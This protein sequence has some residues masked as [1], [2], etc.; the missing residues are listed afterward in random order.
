MALEGIGMR[1]LLAKM[2]IKINKRIFATTIGIALCVMYL[3]GT[4]SMVSGLHTGT[5][6]TADL[7]EK[8]FLVVY[9]GYTLSKSEIE[10]DVITAIP[11]RFAACIIVVANV[12][13][14]ETRVLT[15]EDPHNILGGG[16]ITLI[17]EVL[18]GTGFEIGNV[19]KLEITTD[20][21]S[22]SMNIT[23]KYERY[24]SA[25]FPDNWIL[26]SETTTRSLNPELGDSYSF[27]VIPEDN[28]QAI[29]YFEKNG[30]NIMQSVS[31][32][33][34]FELGFYQVEGNLWAVVASS[35]VV[36]VILVYNVMRIETQYRVPD[37]KIIKYLGASPKIVMYVFLFQALFISCVGASTFSSFR[38][39]L[40]LVLE[41]Y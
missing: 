9:D 1:N 10:S 23:S 12:S 32:V 20:Y 29:S 18:P 16:N 33:E 25:I 39:S 6:N 27:I 17:D 3:V 15:I 30:F 37:I 5:K 7:F 19:S 38:P 26:A 21:A 34:F 8:G 4:M 35:A 2:I 24:T 31:I 28:D 40:Y 22:I 13:G 41:L 36:I 14:V 11:G